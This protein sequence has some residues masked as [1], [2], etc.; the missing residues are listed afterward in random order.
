VTYN[1]AD[2][3]NTPASKLTVLAPSASSVTITNIINNGNNTVTITYGGGAGSNFILMQ[4][5]A[6]P[7]SAGV[8]RDNWTPVATNNATPG[9]FTAIPIG[10]GPEFYTIR[11]K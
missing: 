2:T 9:S 10:A 8:T 7:D 11:S 5:A 6:V 1:G 4:S 3:L